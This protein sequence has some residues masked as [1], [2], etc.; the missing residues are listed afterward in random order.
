ML[1]TWDFG[2]QH[3]YHATHQF[4]LTRRSI[5]LI[6]WNARLGVEQGRIYYW[7]ET[8]KALAP[9]APVLLVATY[10]DERTPDINYQ[11]LKNT[12]PQLVGHLDVSNKTGFGLDALKEAL[13]NHASEL[14]LVGQ[15]WPE[16]WLEV[17]QALQAWSEHHISARTYT[18][19][20]LEKRI[21]ESVA[22]GTLADYLHDLGK[23]LY[24]R[25]D[26]ILRSIVVLKPNW[27]TKAIS[28]VLTDKEV[29]N[30]NGVLHHSELARIW[31]IDEEG[32]PYEQSLY[33]V[34]LRLMERFDLSYQIEDD[35]PGT[36]SSSLIPQ[37][38]SY[39]PPI[40]LPSWPELLPLEKH[41]WKWYIASILFLQES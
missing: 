2:G 11:Q 28:L 40:T 8:I 4:F 26:Y 17:E 3:I 27:I 22:K 33:P 13:A 1:N 38:L 29:S 30:T 6:A 20:C 14:P 23:I 16:K 35:I 32:Q 25:D 37:L 19:Y 34:F 41:S 24:F 18:D 15:P 39:Q 9:D 10:R 5:Y 12:Y 31:A 7:L 36:F 21:E